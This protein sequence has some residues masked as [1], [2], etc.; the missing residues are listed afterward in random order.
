MEY[1]S[2]LLIDSIRE[3]QRFKILLIIIILIFVIFESYNYFSYSKK[4]GV[5]KI[6]ALQYASLGLYAF[7]ASLFSCLLESPISI[8]I[9]CIVL[10]FLRSVEKDIIKL[11]LLRQNARDSN[12]KTFL[13]NWISIIIL[14]FI[15]CVTVNVLLK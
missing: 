14:T 13:S 11:E 4:T 1:I 5:P 7:S 10:V 8:A 3:G 12:L 2:D 9:I 15:T 6:K